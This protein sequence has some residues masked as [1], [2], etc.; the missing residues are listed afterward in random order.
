MTR[1]DSLALDD[2]LCYALY[3]ASNALT[4]AYRPL[5]ERIGLT[6]P[7]YLVMLVLWEGEPRPV[8]ALA[9]RLRLPANALTPLLDRLERAGFVERRRDERDRR[10]VQVSLTASGAA[11][12]PAASEVRGRV[13]CGTGLDPDELDALRADLMAM[14]ERM[15]PEEPPASSVDG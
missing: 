12:R 9:S 5:L 13:A 14:V 3:A 10:V 4:R 11:L 15:E 7:Q 8:R 1:D 2:Q 6:Y